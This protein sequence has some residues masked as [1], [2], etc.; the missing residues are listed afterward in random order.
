MKQP[1]ISLKILLRRFWKKTILTWL[2]VIVEGIALLFIPLVIG[3]AVDDLILEKTRG[4]LQLG[5]V[6]LILLI[7]GAGRR[8][9]DTR[10]YSGIYRKVSGELV[11]R[12]Q[13]R[14]TPLSKI[15]ARANLFTEF[16]GFLENSLPAIFNQFVGLVGTLCIIAVIDFRIFPVCLAGA[17]LTCGIF[18]LSQ[19]KI[20]VLNKGQNDEFE[21][22]VDILAAH[23]PGSLGKHFHDLMGWNIKLSDLETLNFSLTWIVLAGVLLYSIV[24]AASSDA[25]SF[26]RVVSIVMYV[27]GFI[28]SVM[29]FPRHYQQMIRLNDIAARMG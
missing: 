13:D 16:I 5:A 3:W 23:S 28:S 4:L 14:K 24:V 19:K 22:Q 17:F 6:C 11:R 25:S 29:A 15:S 20:L 8:F 10:V 26:G 18:W 21:K 7:G 1:T 12:E 2:L 27:F 9:Y